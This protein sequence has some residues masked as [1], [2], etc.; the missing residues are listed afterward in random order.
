MSDITGA[1]YREFMTPVQGVKQYQSVYVTYLHFFFHG[2]KRIKIR[3]Y[4]KLLSSSSSSSS[5]FTGF[6]NPLAGFSLLILWGFEITHKDAPQSVGLLWT[7]DQPV[8]ETSTWQTHNTH[9]KQTSMSP[10]GFEPAI[11]AGERLQTHALDRS[12]TGIAKN[13]YLNL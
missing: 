1:D 13:Y 8:A 4:I 10:A 6:Y 5:S 2:S 7:S 11:P 12:A 9:N 3:P